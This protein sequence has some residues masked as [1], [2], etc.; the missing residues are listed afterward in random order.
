MALGGVMLPMGGRKGM[1]L[2]V[3][4]DVF[5]GVLSGSAFAGGVT[6]PYDTNKAA[7]VGHFLVAAKADLFMGLEEFKERMDT[8]YLSV[9]G[10]ERAEGVKR[11]Y[12][13]GEREQNCRREREERG[14]P[15]VHAEIDALNAEAAMVGLENLVVS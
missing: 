6:G 8:L 14:I 9:V 11:I 5:G 10:S 13:P 3:C 7:D 15:M 12:F 2:A 1:G 4:M